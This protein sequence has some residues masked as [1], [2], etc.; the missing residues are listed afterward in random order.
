MKKLFYL[1]LIGICL[2]FVSGAQSTAKDWFDKGINAKNDK[3][4]NDAVYSFK[5]AAELKP[6]YGDAWY[7]LGWCYNELEKYNEAAD[8]LK[9]AIRNENRIAAVYY[10]LGWA[11]DNLERTDDAILNY[12]NCINKDESYSVAYRDRAFVYYSLKKDYSRALNDYTTYIN[13][14]GADNISD[15]KVFYRKGWCESE[16]EKFSEAIESLKKAYNLQPDDYD[17]NNELGYVYDHTNNTDMALY[18][19]R[20]ASSIKPGEPSPYI[21]LANIYRDIKK[22]ISTA[23]S[24]Y[25]ASLNKSTSYK[26]AYYGLA[27]CHNDL[28]NYDSALYYTQKA[29]N[30]DSKYALAYREQGY[31]YYKK[32]MY[33]S[34]INSLSTAIQLSP[35][36]GSAIYYC[37]LSY[38]RNKQKSDALKMYD[39]LKAMNSKNAD[40]LYDEISKM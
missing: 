35:N 39:K 38:V 3:L 8:A 31:A 11:Y 23:M 6:D 18:H 40:K 29:I 32:A 37:G 5:K 2:P 4:Y 17:V 30:L 28:N 13:L 7:Q 24:L 26:S 33:Y 34:A 15:Y 20:K 27:W 10:E 36:D 25:F 9:S 16:F 12:T 14:V 22:D 19:Y 1:L 21:N